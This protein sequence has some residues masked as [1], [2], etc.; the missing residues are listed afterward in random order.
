VSDRVGDD[1]LPV[2]SPA[3][4]C[5]LQD[6]YGK[7]FMVDGTNEGKGSKG[8]EGAK[9]SMLVLGDAGVLWKKERQTRLRRH[10]QAARQ[11]E[12]AGLGLGR[13]SLIA[14]TALGSAMATPFRGGACSAGLGSGLHPNS[15]LFLVA[16]SS[17][18]LLLCPSVIC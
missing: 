5:E 2:S 9:R 16:L 3:K 15:T 7:G 17:L 18:L 13:G 6:Y 12:S 10:R 14:V 11:H 4:P 1:D 8:R